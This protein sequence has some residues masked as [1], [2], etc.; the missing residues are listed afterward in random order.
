MYKTNN[1]YKPQT[2]IKRIL[3]TAL[4]FTIIV[5]P[6]N[7]ISN[8][9]YLT[10][11]FILISYILIV[12]LNQVEELMIDEGILILEQKSIFHFL[13]SKTKINL[14]YIISIKT[15][16]NQT[17]NDRGWMLLRGIQKNILELTLKNGK[18]YTIQESLYPKGLKELKFLIES[19][20]NLS[21]DKIPV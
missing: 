17:T 4:F 18:T 6:I 9:S 20:M 5:I 10:W 15:L 1:F 11:F 21:K 16:S 8:F 13:E 2:W 19:E 12:V 3:F 14:S 7:T